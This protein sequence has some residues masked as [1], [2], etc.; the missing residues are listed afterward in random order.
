RRNRATVGAAA[1]CGAGP[2]GD[3]WHHRGGVRWNPSARCSPRAGRG[4]ADRSRSAGGVRSLLAPDLMPERDAK[5]VNKLG[6]HARP[7]AEIVKT[8]GKFSSNITIVRDDLEVN[9]HDGDIAAEFPGRQIGRA[10]V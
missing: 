7:A 3:R 5:I 10:H 2:G 6:I 1:D 9:A 4:L 8:A